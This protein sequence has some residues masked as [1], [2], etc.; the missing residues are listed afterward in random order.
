[1]HLNFSPDSPKASDVSFQ[2]FLNIDMRIG[3]VIEVLDFPEARNP[4]F[5]LCIM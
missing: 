3:E 4:S 5:K 1:M 2:D